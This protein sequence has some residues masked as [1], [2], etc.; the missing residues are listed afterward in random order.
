MSV[1]DLEIELARH[2]EPSRTVED[3]GALPLTIEDALAYRSAGNLPDEEGRS[4]RLVLY[5]DGEPLSEKRLRFEPDFHEAP[6]WRREG[7]MPV[8]VVPLVTGQR[9]DST[10]E[11]PW[12]EQP[13]VA[14][15]EAEWQRT[16][17]V[18]GLAIPAGFRS[19]VFKTIVS[20]RTAGIDVSARAILDSVSRWLSP[21]QVSQLQR[22]FETDDRK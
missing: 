19:F 15:L 18:D 13:D 22:A 16:G 10:T 6:S 9:P 1:R 17:G 7:S 21:E 8:N 14:P 5:V 3:S 4:L 20:L 11:L 12:W 2:R